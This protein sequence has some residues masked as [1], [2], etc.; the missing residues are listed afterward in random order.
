MLKPIGVH[1]RR[2]LRDQDCAGFSDL[3]L[4]PGGVRKTCQPNTLCHDHDP[5]CFLSLRIQSA[6]L[7]RD[8]FFILDIFYNLRLAF[9]DDRGV[10]QSNPKIVAKHYLRGWFTLDV[11]AG[12]PIQHIVAASGVQD[13][14]DSRLL[15]TLRLIRMTRMLRVAKIKRMLQKYQNSYVIQ[16]CELLAARRHPNPAA[17]LPAS[18]QEV[19]VNSSL[20]CLADLSY[21]V[22]FL[23]I[24][25]TAHFLTCFWF[26]IGTFSQ[27]VEI[28]G[29]VERE[30]LGLMGSPARPGF[31]V[32]GIPQLPVP[33]NTRQMLRSMCPV[34]AGQ[35][36]GQDAET[37]H[38]TRHETPCCLVLVASLISVDSSGIA[39]TGHWHL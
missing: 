15:K 19:D 32:R 23:S 29:W 24:I 27:S 28:F 12:I 39:R 18:A 11:I 10:R 33:K 8:I 30:A 35:D 37:R 1:H 17:T 2:L 3:G 31:N 26:L 14:A 34:I 36:T 38:R 5:R 13:Q 21:F 20:A 9:Y 22:L 16:Q 6:D 4:R 25:F 7:L